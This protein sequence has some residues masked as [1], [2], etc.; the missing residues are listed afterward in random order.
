PG[1]PPHR[2]D[3]HGDLRRDLRPQPEDLRPGAPDAPSA[4]PPQV[5]GLRQGRALHLERPPQ[6]GLQHQVGPRD[7]VQDPAPV[8]PP[9]RVPRR[10]HGRP[11][12]GEERPGP[13]PGPEVAPIPDPPRCIPRGPRLYSPPTCFR[14]PEA[15]PPEAR[16]RATAVYG[17]L[18]R[19]LSR[20][21]PE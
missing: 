1:R 8:P 2:R 4:D 11:G 13:A 10:G 3:G 14:P 21:P 16:R 5:A 7:Q 6:P 18:R 20:P 12:Q 19:G 9:H 17:G 15:Y